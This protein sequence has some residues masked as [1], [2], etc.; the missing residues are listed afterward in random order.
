[1]G[2]DQGD[3]GKGDAI[4]ETAFRLMMERGF[5]KT[6]YS[7][8]ARLNDCTKALVQYYYPKKDALMEQFVRRMLELGEEF[9]DA[10]GLKSDSC[11]VDFYSSGYIHYHFLLKNESML[12]LT[13][14]LLATRLYSAAALEEMI[15]WQHRYPELA[16]IDDQL[17]ADSVLLSAGGAYDLIHYHLRQ[18][19]PIDIPALLK[20]IILTLIMDLGLDPSDYP[21]RFSD[22]L[23][24]EEVLAEAN[25]YLFSNMVRDVR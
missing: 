23:L 1:M 14:D 3:G 6:S 11:F 8:I 13:R 22:H 2:F 17:I 20:K 15:A 9:L 4:R 7:E 5:A 24:S 19:I 10:R 18:G 25:E 12:P 21:E 16:G